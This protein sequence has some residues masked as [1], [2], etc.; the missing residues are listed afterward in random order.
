MVPCLLYLEYNAKSL[1]ISSPG[2]FYYFTGLL[3]SFLDNTPTAVTFYSLAS[4]LGLTAP[5]MIAGIP[6]IIMEAICLGAVFFGSMT[7]IGNGPNFMV[8]A[9]AEENNI[10]MPS[11]F[12]Y[13]FKFSL[14]V[15]LPVYIL[16]EFLLL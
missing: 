3:S 2:Q 7:Y 9:V 1:G 10:N 6:V 13:M 5:E 15:L 16:T 14:I 8:K 11:F 4:G 12:G